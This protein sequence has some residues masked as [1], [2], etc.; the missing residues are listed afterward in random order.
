M[1]RALHAFVRAPRRGLAVA[2]GVLAL[3]LGVVLMHAMSG[4]PMA[5]AGPIA[6]L[7]VVAHEAIGAESLGGMTEA[8]HPPCDGC[9]ADGHDVTGAM[10]MI[11]LTMLLIF[12]LPGAAVRV[13]WLASW[14]TA[15]PLPALPAAG[16]RPSLDAL[17]ISR[18]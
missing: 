7:E 6:V 13:P 17:G 11:V 16:A 14:L 9:H 15:T 10:C 1:V 4:S 3:A 5:H 8:P 2:L 12:S 18:T